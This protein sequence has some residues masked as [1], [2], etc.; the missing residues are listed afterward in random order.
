MSLPLFVNIKQKFDNSFLT[1]PA[2]SIQ[3]ELD[4]VNISQMIN[5]GD[6][7]GIAVGS[8][9][10]NQLPLLLKVLVENVLDM[11]ASPFFIPAMGSHG[12]ARAKKQSQIVSDMVG[13]ELSSIP[14][15]ATMDVEDVGK[16]RSGF[17]V[18]F[19]S[20]A[21]K[22]EKIIIANRI[23]P[24][25]DFRGNF[26]S[27]LLKMLSIGLGKQ[28]GAETCHV[29]GKKLGL[30]RVIRDAADKIIS[31]A[32]V[33]LGIGIVENAYNK[34]VKIQAV[35]PG[36]FWETEQIMF[37]QAIELMPKLPFD[38]IDILIIDEIGKEISGNGMDPNITGRWEG[39]SASFPR[40][41]QIFVRDLS[42]PS[43]GNAIGIGLAD[44]TTKRMVN[45]IDMEAT[46]VNCLTSLSLESGKIP[47]SFK[48]DH[49]AL[50]TLAEIIPGNPEELKMVWI[51][52]TSYLEKCVVSDSYMD[53][54]KK[55][56]DLVLVDGPF[57][58][59]F[60]EELNLISFRA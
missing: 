42:I 41:G 56:P 15:R 1:D 33:V 37:S 46:K 11:G 38:D 40:I 20:D 36:K 44:A 31:C 9:G 54:I 3:S 50:M 18:Y 55:R 6:Q 12:S 53:K 32:P 5:P 45:R 7:V 57:D 8:R 35:T 30:G 48:N 43:R 58:L 17:D 4:R 52:S 39:I 24:H 25:T 28:K 2:G 14:I 59:Q 16:T 29:V 23:K 51:K 26:G 10:I 47:I 60:D 34:I 27:G 49:E 13:N 21:L 22:A 19:S